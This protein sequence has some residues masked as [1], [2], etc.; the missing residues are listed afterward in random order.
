MR[1]LWKALG[2][3]FIVLTIQPPVMSILW[4]N[5]EPLLCHEDSRE[6]RPPRPVDGVEDE[7]AAWFQNP[8][9]LAESHM[10]V[11]QVL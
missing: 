10:K 4:Q 2:H 1:E 8:V 3:L 9:D 7:D 5:S 11:V 6:P